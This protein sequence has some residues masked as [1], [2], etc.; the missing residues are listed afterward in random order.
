MEDKSLRPNRPV[1]GNTIPGRII[2]PLA[3]KPLITETTKIA[4]QASDGDCPIVSTDD[5]QIAMHNLE[6]ALTAAN[7]PAK[8]RLHWER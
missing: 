8:R 5:L 7:I 3:A 6:T 1:D 2:R 4:Q